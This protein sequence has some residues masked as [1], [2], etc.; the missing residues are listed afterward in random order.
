M[1]KSPKSLIPKK[2]LSLFLSLQRLPGFLAS[3][4]RHPQQRSKRRQVPP[5]N[6]FASQRLLHLG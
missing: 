4:W 1:E 3:P 5:A 6:L 2:Q